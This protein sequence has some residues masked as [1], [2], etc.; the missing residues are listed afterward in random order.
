MQTSFKGSYQF[1]H[2]SKTFV[3]IYLIFLVAEWLDDAERR[4][5]ALPFFKL[6]ETTAE[7]RV[8]VGSF[9]DSDS[10]IGTR[11]YLCGMEKSMIVRG[12]CEERT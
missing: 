6:K 12:R 9:A 11:N 5:T 1:A 10:N 8:D 2:T 7:T 3:K 4:P